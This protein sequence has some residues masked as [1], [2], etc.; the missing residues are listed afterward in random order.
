MADDVWKAPAREV[1]LIQSSASGQ[2]CASVDTDELTARR[3]ADT[4]NS[5]RIGTAYRVVGP[6]VLAGRSG[7]TG[8]EG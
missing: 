6:Y 5:P 8:D 4:L 2:L 3:L 7:S 1:W